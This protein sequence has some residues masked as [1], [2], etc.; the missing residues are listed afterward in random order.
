M[1]VWTY[2]IAWNEAVMARW[3]VRHYAPW[4][5]KIIVYVEPSTDGTEQILRQ[6]PNVEVRTWPYVGLDDERMLRFYQRCYLEARGKADWVALVDMDE[7]L[8]HHDM[9]RL[10][11][12][13]HCE[14]LQAEG[15]A[16]LS[17]DGWPQ[18]DGESQLYDFVPTGIKQ[19]NYDK[20]ILFRPHVHMVHTIGRHSYQGQF[21]KH[22]GRECRDTGLKLLHCHYV[23]GP[24]YTAQRNK[25]N[26][27]RCPN[28][29]YAWN[30][31]SHDPKQVGTVEW[32]K[33][34]LDNDK[35]IAVV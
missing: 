21:P 7:L 22:N 5:E 24:D 13:T 16:L 8:Y 35:L 17:K 2:T 25:R 4:A 1:R 15:F 26:Y 10:L 29:K 9:N 18:D 14:V 28:K 30:M 33:D 6:Y 23:G 11:S 32:V 27:D 34:A 3:F 12:N 31:V 20:K 19:V